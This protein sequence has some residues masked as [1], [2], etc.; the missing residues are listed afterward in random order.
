MHEQGLFGAMPTHV[1]GGQE[2][3]TDKA[4][5]RAFFL[6]GVI[7]FVV[8]GRGGQNVRARAR[9][10]RRRGRELFGCRGHVRALFW[11]SHRSA[12][13]KLGRFH[14]RVLMERA[15]TI[16]LRVAMGKATATNNY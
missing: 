6:F 9:L 3:C 14:V 13:T 2:T 5:A 15:E 1:L 11:G 16:P 7:V 12:R 10:G 8:W 4:Y